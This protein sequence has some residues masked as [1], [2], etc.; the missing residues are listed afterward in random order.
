MKKLPEQVGDFKA[1]RGLTVERLKENMKREMA[2]VDIDEF[3][4]NEGYMSEADIVF[5]YYDYKDGGLG[6]T[7]IHPSLIGGEVGYTICSELNGYL[8]EEGIFPIGKE[9]DV[10]QAYHDTMIINTKEFPLS[11]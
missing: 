10:L 7:F 8:T 3:V 9:E 11:V 6:S 4:A 1:I 2:K 5:A